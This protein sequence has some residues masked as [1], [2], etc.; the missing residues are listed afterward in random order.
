MIK[1]VKAWWAGVRTKALS[2]RRA[3]TVRFFGGQLVPYE[4]KKTT[5]ID[6]GYKGNDIVYSI[7]RLIVT[8]A[9]IA[10]WAAYKVKDAKAYRDLQNELNKKDG[11]LKV[12]RALHRKA[13]ELYT[14]NEALTRLLERPN[15]NQTL[16]DLHDELWSYK[17][18]TGEY[19]EYWEEG[20]SGGLAKGIPRSLSALP[21]PHMWIESGTK[22]PLTAKMY[23]L[24]LGQ[25]VEFDPKLILHEKYPNLDWDTYGR[26]LYGQPPLLAALRRLQRNNEAQNASAAQARNGGRQGIVSYDDPRIDLSDPSTWEQMGRDKQT[27]E[28]QMGDPSMDAGKTWFSTFGVKYT[29][30]GY[31]PADLEL[32]AS[33]MIDLRFL[34]NVFGVPSQLLN[35]DAAKTYNTVTE[36]EKALIIRAVLPLLTA[37]RDSLTFKLNIP[38]IV[39]DFDLSVYDQL[40]PNKVQIA[41]W[42]NKMPLTNKRKLEIIGED[43]D[44]NMSDEVANAI[45]V[46]T[47]FVNIEDL[48]IPPDMGAEDDVNSLS[49]SGNNPY[50][51]PTP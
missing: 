13:L 23:K 15:E 3:I 33:E 26:Q 10:P 41:E 39:I 32:L 16:G 2:V 1:Q 30:V 22:L 9:K 31:S 4:A 5:F 28:D 25:A 45:L 14:D 29:Q 8:V 20:P 49:S 18:V 17:L 11:N 7:V 35:D 42:V 6:K 51:G 21:S 40:Q 24:M 12:I 38:G 50:D 19:Y 46:P 36:A 47:G 43:V 44:A 37:R 48:L 34:C 27:F